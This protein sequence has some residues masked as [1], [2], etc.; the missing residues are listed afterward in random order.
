MA[1]IKGVISKKLPKGQWAEA[2]HETGM[3]VI[4]PKC[5]G[6]K[7]ME[8]ID[9]E[10]LHILC[11]WMSEDAV[12]IIASELTRIRW[13]RGYRRIDSDDSFDLQDVEHGLTDSAYILGKPDDDPV[14]ELPA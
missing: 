5:K 3:I 6:I 1:I 10:G 13:A 9:H 2:D 7:D 4:D 14:A 11:P 8:M 12:R